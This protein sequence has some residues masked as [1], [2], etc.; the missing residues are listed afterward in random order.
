MAQILPF[1]GLLY[2]P[3]EVSG[4]DVIAPPYDVIS[5]EYKEALY[6]KSPYNIVRID[7]GKALDGD[8][9]TNNKYTRA[10]ECMEKWVKEKVLIRDEAPAFYG[11]EIDYVHSGNRRKLRGILAL[12]KLEELGQG[13]Y[14]HEETHSKPKADRLDLMRSCFGNISPIYSLYNSP[15]KI[16]STILRDMTEAPF[17]S[18]TDADGARHSIYRVT[19]KSK[20]DSIIKEFNDKPIFI[21]DGHHRYEVAL[22]FKKEMDKEK[23]RELNDFCPWDYVMMFLANMSDEGIAILPTHRLVRGIRENDIFRKLES[24]FDITRMPKTDVSAGIPPLEGKNVFGFYMNRED[25]WH[26]LR[27]KGKSLPDIHPALKDLDVV[28]LHEL[29]LKRDLGITDIVYEM[30]AAEAIKRVQRGEFDGLFLLNPTGIEDVER[31]ALS[32]LRMPPKSTYFY[33]KVL[34]GMVINLFNNKI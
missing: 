26:I 34:T 31:V 9:D 22:E 13:I 20:I 7:A 19:D 16:A 21:A 6:L 17:I 14:P 5:P 3:A 4:D 23:R 2:N 28:V 27:Y 30:D 29:I 25:V 33:P 8:T 10:R 32:H 12:V 15:Q 18:G 1:R 11:Y 24:D